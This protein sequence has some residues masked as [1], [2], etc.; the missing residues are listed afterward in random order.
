MAGPVA[1]PKTKLE[2]TLSAKQWGV[3]Y[4]GP[5]I[6]CY[7]IKF[8]S[9]TDPLQEGGDP[10]IAVYVGGDRE[11]NL[12]K[13]LLVGQ[14]IEV[15]GKVIHVYGALRG[16]QVARWETSDSEATDWFE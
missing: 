11:A 13:S 10:V 9:L 1:V 8:A 12:A 5:K 6:E 2:R 3:V 7:T 4:I 15:C 16:A 14:S